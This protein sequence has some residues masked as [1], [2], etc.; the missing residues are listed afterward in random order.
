V[1][2]AADQLLAEPSRQEGGCARRR[3]FESN[4]GEDC[5]AG[6]GGDTRS[7]DA[8][9]P[10]RRLCWLTSNEVDALGLGAV[11]ASAPSGATLVAG[12]KNSG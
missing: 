5:F 10:W 9:A 2:R 11:C 12:F 6:A 7:A 8:V 4:R 3:I 1:A